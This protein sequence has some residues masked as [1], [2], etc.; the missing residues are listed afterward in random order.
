MEA[1]IDLFYY[2]AAAAAV[3]QSFLLGM[4]T[5]EHRRY[6]R[7][8]MKSLDCHQ[9]AGRVLVC[10][11]CK[12]N[13][14]NLE[15]NLR[16]LLE[17]DYGDYEVAFI[18]ESEFDSAVPFIRRA[19]AAHPWM[20]ARLIVAGRA[21]DCGQKVHNLRVATGRL[22]PR[23]EYL[24]FI[25]SDAR[26][27]PEWLRMLVARL[28]R[29]K[30]GAITGYR[31][32][33]PQSDSLANR[34]LYSLNCDLMAL[35]G[36]SSHHLVWGGSWA[37]RRQVFELV[38]LHSA[39][40]NT[41]S[42]DFTAGRVLRDAGLE[43]RFEPACVVAS[44]IDN[45]LREAT[46]FL[47]RQYLLTKLY[48][49][50]WWLFAVLGFSAANLLWLGNLAVLAW[51]FCGGPVSAWIP[52]AVTIALYLARVYRGAVRQD[53]VEVYFPHLKKTLERCKRFD[54]WL[55]PLVGL[56][57]WT[58]ILSTTVGKHVN[59]RGIGYSLF[60]NG[61]VKT[62]WRA[63]EPTTLPLASLTKKHSGEWRV[64]SGAWALSG[65]R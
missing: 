49:R 64:K 16:A 41:L 60:P 61:K 17:Q 33:V 12:G 45:N 56:F 59:W 62:I 34:L 1:Y 5:W 58:V 6:V 21:V 37:I 30:L 22:S 65:R 55:N 57:H 27:R 47:R 26:P 63:D 4:Q 46:S 9:P 10:A 23:I 28:Q 38:G 40:K 15:D 7:S 51:S 52:A 54:V 11:P 36:R 50:Q 39:W 8:C 44:P 43:V 42:D 53:L 19:M 31:W 25:D 29:P 35:L 32:F 48:A 24:A 3:V 14:V 13:D 20:P 2:F 18:V